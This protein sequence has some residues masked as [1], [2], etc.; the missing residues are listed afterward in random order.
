M[1]QKKI[2]ESFIQEKG[3]FTPRS[4]VIRKKYHVIKSE[5]YKQGCVLIE[6]K[7]FDYLLKLTNEA[8]NARFA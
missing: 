6:K 7:D 1:D 3:I 4:M 5:R 2:D 8:E